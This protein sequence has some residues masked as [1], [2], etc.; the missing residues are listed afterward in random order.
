MCW[1]SVNAIISISTF[2]SFNHLRTRISHTKEVHHKI[3]TI[4]PSSTHCRYIILYQKSDATNLLRRVFDALPSRVKVFDTVAHWATY[5]LPRRENWREN[6]M[7]ACTNLLAF[8]TMRVFLLQTF[9]KKRKKLT[10]IFRDGARVVATQRD[11]S[12][13]Q[14]CTQ[15]H[16]RI[17]FAKRAAVW[18]IFSSYCVCKGF[19]SGGRDSPRNSKLEGI[20]LYINTARS[21]W[22]I[23]VFVNLFEKISKAVSTVSQQMHME[24]CLLT[25]C[26]CNTDVS[27]VPDELLCLILSHFKPKHQILCARGKLPL[28]N[29]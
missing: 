20:G 26:S 23:K 4:S 18:D 16:G 21:L 3:H 28:I 17:I 5:T 1:I 12:W 27:L 6:R 10:V 25:S 15:L 8:G 14:A 2:C 13:P 24:S 29:E 7:L 11:H 19:L 9:Q 22:S